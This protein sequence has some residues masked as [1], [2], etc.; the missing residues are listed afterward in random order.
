[1]QTDILDL[2][3]KYDVPTPRYTSYPTVPFWNFQ[4]LSLEDWKT[5]VINTYQK[6]NGE[7]CLYIHLPFCEELCTYC[8][9]NKR[10]TTN[11]NVET[12]YLE[13]V[14]KEW[15]MY[16]QLFNSKPKIREIHLG[17]GTPTFFHRNILHNSLLQ[18]LP[19]L[20]L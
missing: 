11:H 13:S 12:P 19:M 17:G 10:I 8:A 4:S 3:T 14:L 20:L 5:S 6:E 7:I 16:L 18:L 9:C 15:K 2:L 1:M